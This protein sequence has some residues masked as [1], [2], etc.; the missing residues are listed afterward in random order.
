[1]DALD[2]AVQ[3][4]R[5]MHVAL[6]VAMVLYVIIGENIRPQEPKDLG[7]VATALVILGIM[8]A[9]GQ[10]FCAGCCCS[11]RN[12][13]CRRA[14]TTAQRSTAG[15]WAISSRS[16]CARPSRS[17]ASSCA[18]SAGPYSTRSCSTPAASS[19]SFCSP[20]AARKN[21]PMATL[22]LHSRAGKPA[23]IMRL[24]LL[25]A[26]RVLKG[27]QGRQPRPKRSRVPVQ[28]FLF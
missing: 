12:R 27:R 5:K 25:G 17:M 11:L 16:C 6:L 2:N 14:Q 15:A 13:P 4:L 8:T 9:G 7:L 21:L 18:Y 24:Q 22:R 26:R 19:C 28:R 10:S 23:R 3:P 20:L 1:L